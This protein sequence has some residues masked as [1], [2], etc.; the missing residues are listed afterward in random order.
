[1]RAKGAL[2][3][4]ALHSQLRFSVAD[5]LRHS[6]LRSATTS[7]RRAGSK[8]PG[9]VAIRPSHR[10]TPS[11]QLSEDGK[12]C[13]PSASLE[14]HRRCSWPMA[15]N[16]RRRLHQL[17]LAC[18][19]SPSASSSAFRPAVAGRGCS[20]GKTRRPVQRRGCPFACKAALGVPSPASRPRPSLSSLL[21][22]RGSAS[23]PKRWAS[24]QVEA[25]AAAPKFAERVPAGW[26][27]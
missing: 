6:Q 23:G 8:E 20:S 10:R 11:S 17:R 3:G 13:R 24:W 4:P 27:G 21:V 2:S 15:T 7:S 22:A 25:P 16:K 5:Q 9:I 1:M 26:L 19:C 12:G 18:G 14:D